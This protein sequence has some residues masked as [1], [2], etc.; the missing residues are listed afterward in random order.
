M[1]TPK[2]PAAMTMPWVC[3]RLAIE[4]T[5]SGG[6]NDPDMNAVA[7]LP[8]GASSVATV[9]TVTPVTNPPIVL[10]N[11]SASNGACAFMVDAPPSFAVTH[12]MVAEFAG[13]REV[14]NAPAL[15]VVFGHAFLGETLEFVGGARS[16]RAQQAIAPDFLGRAAVIDLIEFVAS[17]EFGRD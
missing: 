5:Q 10:R 9:T 7:V 1:L 14:G 6:A 2:R 15:E 12:Q 17:A 16:L 3:A 11:S 4:T 13:V 8:C